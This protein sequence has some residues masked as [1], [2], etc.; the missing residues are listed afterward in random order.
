MKELKKIIKRYE[1][2]GIHLRKENVLK[3]ITLCERKMT[4]AKIENKTQYMPLIFE[5]ELKNMVIRDGINEIT[6]AYMTEDA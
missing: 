6:K 1:D 4:L 3:L 2:K 5:D